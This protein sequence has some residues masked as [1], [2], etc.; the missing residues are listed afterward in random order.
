MEIFTGEIPKEVQ[1]DIEKEING[2]FESYAFLKEEFEEAWDE[3]KKK[4][5]SRDRDKLIHELTQVAAV[6][7]RTIVELK[8]NKI[9]F[10]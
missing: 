7:I 9:K 2:L 8:E 3:I 4:E 5:G 6:A 10:V 1:S